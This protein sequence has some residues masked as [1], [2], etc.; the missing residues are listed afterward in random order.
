MQANPDKVPYFSIVIATYNRAHMISRAIESVINQEYEDWE[1]IVVDDGSEDDTSAVVL[2][3]KDARIQYHFQENRGRSAARNAGV[4]LSKGKMLCFLD[5]DDWYYSHFMI[6]MHEFIEKRGVEK[7]LY[8]CAQDQY[9]QEGNK[10]GESGRWY[11]NDPVKYVL[12]SANNIEPVI[13]PMGALE[14][15]RFDERF[16]I[17]EDFHFLLPLVLSYPAHYFE[18]SLLAYKI[19]EG[20]TMEREF[21]DKLIDSLAYNRLDVMQDLWDK[22]RDD[23]RKS[24]HHYLFL[25]KFNKIRYFYASAWMRFGNKRKALKSILNFYFID[26]KSVYFYLS[27]LIRSLIY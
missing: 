26:L 13:F 24:G 8:F 27:I 9:N 21:S 4:E 3:Y 19:H 10:V 22:Y 5:D 12:L 18:E 2:K 1:L 17:G 11:E 25:K 14:H 16:E 20:S 6:R 23:L 7:A 15:H